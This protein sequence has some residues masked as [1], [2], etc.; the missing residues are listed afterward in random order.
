MPEGWQTYVVPTFGG[1]VNWTKHPVA[2]RDD[3]W[4]HA[5]GVLA[6]DGY[7]EVMP[8]YTNLGQ[9]GVAGFQPIGITQNPFSREADPLIVGMVDFGAGAL[10]IKVY[11]VDSLGVDLE[12]T[13]DGTD[14]A[15]GTQA[16]RGQKYAFMGAATMDGYLV[17]SFGGRPTSASYSLIRIP[18]AL[19]TY[20]TIKPTK[21]LTASFLVGFGSHLIAAAR[22]TD[23]S[24]ER[25]LF[26][27]DVNSAAIWDAAVSNSADEITLGESTS[28]ILGL[29]RVGGNALA[30][31]VRDRI[32][33]LSPTGGLPPFTVHD[34]GLGGSYEG[35]LLGVLDTGGAH[36]GETPYGACYLGADNLYLLNGSGR[37]PIGSQ[38]GRVFQTLEPT[39][40]SGQFQWHPRLGVLLVPFG[41]ALFGY[42]PVAQS[43]S[44]HL[45]DVS[46]FNEMFRHAVIQDATASSPR[47][48]IV[49]DDRTLLVENAA[50]PAAGWS[51]ETKD[52]NTG[53]PFEQMHIGELKVEWEPLTNATTDAISVGVAVRDDLSRGVQGLP[54]GEV[55]TS[56]TTVGTLTAGAS[57]IAIRQVGK[58]ARFQFSASSGRSRIR[59]LSFTRRRAGNRPRR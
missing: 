20:Q 12:I 10:P 40:V 50:I 56:F 36:C 25:T 32:Y 28:P 45:A 16:P 24:G 46:A 38:L 11:K 26:V 5:T 47:H 58:F 31:L 8:G 43:W 44:P 17:L 39:L 23:F 7:A 37:T 57:E 18:S 53:E 30:V 27:S 22:G 14:T 29:V 59:G 55:V 42:D 1:G 34:L 9:I 35:S 15:G 21:A 2:L 49:G 19:A 3:E 48:Y 41:D 6:R 54:S 51:V 52:F 13:H 4:A 33:L